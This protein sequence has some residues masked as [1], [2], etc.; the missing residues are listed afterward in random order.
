MRQARI[1]PLQRVMLAQAHHVWSMSN[2]RHYDIQIDVE[3][4]NIDMAGD[5][6][7]YETAMRRCIPCKRIGQ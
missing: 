3:A 5:V 4:I 7:W 2:M 1:V 6:R